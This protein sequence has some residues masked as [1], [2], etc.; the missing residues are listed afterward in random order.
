MKNDSR[1]RTMYISDALWAKAEKKAIA[2]GRSVSAWIRRAIEAALKV[3][4]N[5]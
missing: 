5:P 3:V 4:V 2:D 1:R